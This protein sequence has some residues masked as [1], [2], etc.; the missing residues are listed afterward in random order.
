MGAEVLVVEVQAVSLAAGVFQADDA[1]G[2]VE[3]PIPED[4]GVTAAVLAPELDEV[5]ALPV[6]EAA[7]V[8]A[9]PNA[10]ATA[11]RAAERTALVRGPLQR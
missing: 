9:D 2:V 4:R 6:L 7:N 1:V 5:T 11:A 8:G 3:D 10:G